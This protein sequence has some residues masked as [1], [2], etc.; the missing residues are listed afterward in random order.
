ML[1]RDDQAVPRH[2]AAPAYKTSGAQTAL[3]SGV[4]CCDN[5]PMS[6]RQAALH[7]IRLQAPAG[8]ETALC[9]VFQLCARHRA[10]RL[11]TTS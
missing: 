4:L 7:S 8:C 6:R 10:P 1:G 5:K 3:H 9:S 11:L 2:Q